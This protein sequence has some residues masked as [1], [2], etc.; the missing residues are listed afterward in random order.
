MQTSVKKIA[1]NYLVT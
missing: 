1:G